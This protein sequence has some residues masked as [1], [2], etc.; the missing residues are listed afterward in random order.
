MANDLVMLTLHMESSVFSKGFDLSELFILLNLFGFHEFLKD[1]KVILA[2]EKKR[3]DTQLADF[4]KIY[5]LPHRNHAA[6][7]VE[8][9]SVNEITCKK[10]EEKKYMYM[11]IIILCI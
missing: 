11:I 6:K 3:K 5:L 4:A 2:S 10:N 7:A 1:L 8:A 9:D